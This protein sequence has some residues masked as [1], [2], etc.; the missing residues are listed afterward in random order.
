MKKVLLVDSDPVMRKVFQELLDCRNGFIEVFTAVAAS[1]AAKILHNEQVDLVLTTINLPKVN[2]LKL[3]S[4]CYQKFPDIKIILLAKE[5]HQAISD[6]IQ[7]FPNAILVDIQHD[8][9]MLYR[10]VTTELQIEY[11]GQI[12]GVSLPSFLQ[13]L[14]LDHVS[15]SLKATSKRA[16]GFL[17]VKA[18]ELIAANA[19][20]LKGRK[21]AIEIL[22]W[23][24]VVID[25]NYAPFEKKPEITDRL[26]TMILESGKN[27]DES[28]NL[29]SYS[30]DHE[31]Y[32]MSATIDFGINNKNRQCRLKDISL[33]GA[34][35]ETDQLLDIGQHVTLA[36]TSPALKAHCLVDSKVVYSDEHG[37]GLKFEL[38]YDEQKWMI[39][40]I[41]DSSTKSRFR[42]E[43]AEL[44]IG[45]IA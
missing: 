29:K 6:S 8:I 9:G 40:M 43:Q 12:S 3:I 36:L 1:E 10:R 17:W 30:R 24:S 37:A 20:N 4:Y 2:G 39:Q 21:A 31:R 45:K 25:I 42:K 28:L 23:E 32:E 13:V 33:S 5:V 26:I 16:Y 11:G 38:K 18:G 41:I 7:R 19:G 34:Y 14:E 27:F 35:I 44:A 22:S 15:C